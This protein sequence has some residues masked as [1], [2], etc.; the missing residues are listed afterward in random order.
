MKIKQF[1]FN[2]WQENSYIVYDET[3]ECAIIDAGCFSEQEQNILGSFISD[4]DLMVKYILNTHLHIDHILG[5]SFLKKTF[6]KSPMAHENDEFLIEN[7]KDY[8]SQIGIPLLE[9]PPKVETKLNEGD[10]LQIG[11]FKLHVLHVPGHSPGSIAF[12]NKKRNILF[13]GDVLFYESIGRTDLIYGN[14][15]ALLNGIRRKI[16]TLP[17]ETKVYPGHG[18]QTTVHHELHHNPFL[19]NQC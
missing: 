16:L 19:K 8:A 12:L 11:N 9:T 5:N 14:M 3:K 13:S 4:N 17:E 18:P 10:V 6:N 2:P 7:A 1:M 15:D